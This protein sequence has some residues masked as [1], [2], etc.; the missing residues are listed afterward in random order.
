MPVRWVLLYGYACL[1][2][3]SHL[4]L[5]Y[6]TSYGVRLFEPFSFKWYSWD[7]VYMA[8]PFMWVVLGLG[9]AVPGL[10]GLVNHRTRSYGFK[11]VRVVGLFLPG[12]RLFLCGV[13]ATTSTAKHW[14]S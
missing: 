4:L 9:L 2:V 10:L 1:A 3:L 7:I 11:C 6:T 13:F 8:E 12:W 14:L 5:D